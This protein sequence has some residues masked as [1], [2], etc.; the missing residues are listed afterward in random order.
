MPTDE[1]EVKKFHQLACFRKHSTWNRADAVALDTLRLTDKE[2]DAIRKGHTIRKREWTFS[3][4][5]DEGEL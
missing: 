1:K 3:P 2:K 4:I 5:R